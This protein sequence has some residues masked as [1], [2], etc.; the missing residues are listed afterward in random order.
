MHRW[1]ASA[2][3]RPLF[4][5]QDF[6]AT[7]FSSAAEKAGF[8]NTLLR[9]IETDFRPTLFTRRLYSR[10][11][12]CFGHVAHTNQLGFRDTFFDDLHGKVAFLEQTLAWHCHGQPD[13]T[14]CDVERAT[15]ARLRMRSARDLSRATRGRDRDRRACRARAAPRQVRRSSRRSA[16]RPAALAPHRTAAPATGRL[17][18][19]S[20]RPSLRER[21]RKSACRIT[22]GRRKGPPHAAARLRRLR[23]CPDRR[24]AAD[25]PGLP[26]EEED[27]SSRKEASDVLPQTGKTCRNHRRHLGRHRH[28]PHPLLAGV[29][30]PGGRGHDRRRPARSFRH[31]TTIPQ[32]PM[33]AEL[34]RV[35]PKRLIPNPDNPR[36]TGVPQAMDEQLIASIKAV[37]L[38]QPPRVKEADGQLVIIVGIRRAQAAIAAGLDV[39]DV[40]VCDADEA[41]DAMRSVSENL[42]RASMTS[43]ARQAAAERRLRPRPAAEEG[44]ARLRQAGQARL[45]RSLPRPALRRRENDRLPHP[46]AEEAEDG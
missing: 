12:M 18:G 24:D 4:T 31:L 22:G 16:D 35:D 30:A 45:G 8:A 14:Y 42:I 32:E 10:L 37:G 15:Q 20:A 25:G 33:M 38:I 11:S 28:A 23:P 7:K 6:T 17:D 1:N 13:Y 26:G 21:P 41:A 5:D 46:R 2:L 44:R 19:G 9:F 3:T 40:L 29:S 34:R 27:R 39:I 43:V 36:R